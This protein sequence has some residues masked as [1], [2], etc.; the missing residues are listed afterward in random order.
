MFYNVKMNR[1]KIVLFF[2]DAGLSGGTLALLDLIEKWYREESYDFICIIPKH[3]IKLEDC[4]KKYN[5]EIVIFRFWQAVWDKNGSILKKTILLFKLLLGCLNTW[6]Y[7]KKIKEKD[8]YLVYSNTSSIYNGVIFSKILKVPHIW[9]IRE[10]VAEEHGVYPLLGENRHYNI[11]DKY[12][13]NL[14]FISNSLAQ[15]YTKYIKTKNIRIIYDDISPKYKLEETLD[16]EERKKNILVV[17][18]I[19]KGKGQE[20]VIKAMSKIVEKKYM[21]KLY[22]A[23][24]P[25][26]KEYYE[27]I[28]KLIEEMKLENNVVFLGQIEDLNIVRKKMGIG[29][30]P[31]YKEAFGRVTIEG[32]LAGM[33]MIGANDSGTRELIKD[34]QTGYLFE[35]NNLNEISNIVLKILED[36]KNSKKIIENSQFFAQK[37]IRG[38]CAKEI[39]DVFNKIGD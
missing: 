7:A 2:H 20:L 11:I 28:N 24:R 38:N 21:V 4:L 8:I 1:K 30:V 33:I 32:M 6:I 23:G 14:I 36:E 37:F 15:E 16:W 3:N 18:N 35:F 31:S 17:G 9:H 5:C 25:T 26:D 22:F 29:I 19:S 34:G 12:G 13:D 39:L 27:K 10:F